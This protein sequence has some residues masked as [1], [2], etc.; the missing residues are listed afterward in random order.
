MEENLKYIIS[1]LSGEKSTRLMQMENKLSFIVSKDSNKI[2]IKKE[3]ESLLKAKVE[4]IN[5]INRMDSRKV[6]IVK[7]KPEFQAM[8]IATQLGLI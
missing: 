1:V 6:A 5:I 4:S 3:V 7:L 8:D 2:L